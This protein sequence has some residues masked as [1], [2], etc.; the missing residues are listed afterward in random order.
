[1]RAPSAASASATARPCPCAAPVIKATL[2]L[3]SPGITEPFSQRFSCLQKYRSSRRKENQNPR[4]EQ[5]DANELLL[6]EQ[7]RPESGRGLRALQN[8]SR[9]IRGDDNPPGF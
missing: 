9:G 4:C 6:L 8:A 5:G 2:S 3:N 1:M 7:H